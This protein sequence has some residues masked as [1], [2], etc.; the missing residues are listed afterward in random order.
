MENTIENKSKF[1]SQYHAQEIGFDITQN[2]IR[3]VDAF[4]LA[5][6]KINYLELTQLSLISD[7]DADVIAEIIYGHKINYVQGYKTQLE[8]LIISQW[9]NYK[10]YDYLRSKGY[11]LPFMGLS[12]LQLENYG[13]IKFKQ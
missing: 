9:N 8:L 3:K 6:T 11:A 5:H 1:F 7:E 2:K 13:W 4:F 12:V 10:V